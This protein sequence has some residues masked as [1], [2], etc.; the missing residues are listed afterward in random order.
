[1]AGTHCSDDYVNRC[2]SS[3]AYT[4]NTLIPVT[5]DNTVQDFGNCVTIGAEKGTCGA[6]ENEPVRPDGVEVKVKGRNVTAQ[7]LTETE[8]ECV[9]ADPDTNFHDCCGSETCMGIGSDLDFPPDC[10]LNSDFNSNTNLKSDPSNSATSVD[11]ESM[12]L[13]NAFEVEIGGVNEQTEMPKKAK[14]SLQEA[15]L[16][17]RKKRQDDMRQERRRR[18]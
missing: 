4:D 18:D 14:N 11:P 13:T 3:Y 5:K 1:M 17:F 7:P 6:A 8:S 10:S 15:F 2:K 9:T 12:K 16:H